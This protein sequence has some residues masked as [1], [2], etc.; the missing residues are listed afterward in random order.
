[1]LKKLLAGVITAVLS[2]GAV[3]LI[4]GPASASSPPAAVLVRQ[5]RAWFRGGLARGSTHK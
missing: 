3:A 1:M 4:A 2:L 5:H